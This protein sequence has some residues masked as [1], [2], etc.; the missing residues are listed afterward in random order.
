MRCESREAT[1]CGKVFVGGPNPRV[2]NH[3]DTED[4]ESEGGKDP[5]GPRLRGGGA[6]SS[7][8]RLPPSLR[9]SAV[10]PAFPG[11][12]IRGSGGAEYGLD[13]VVFL[14]FCCDR[15]FECDVT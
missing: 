2:T 11:T 9:V 10:P 15:N 7:A 6:S 1:P 8:S 14:N 5:E 12:L 13:G 4:T 3:G